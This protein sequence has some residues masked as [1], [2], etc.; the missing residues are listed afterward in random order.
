M[1]CIA[2]AEIRV[3]R[4]ALAEIIGEIKSRQ[5]LREG[6]GSYEWNDDDYRREAGWCMDA[7]RKIAEVALTTPAPAAPP[8]TTQED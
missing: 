5:W 7:V 6:R 3:Y 4:Q 2:C 1:D 8:A